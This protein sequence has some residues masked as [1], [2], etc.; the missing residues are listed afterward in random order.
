MK[1]LSM[2][3]VFNKKIYYIILFILLIYLS[4]SL[5]GTKEVRF[6]K[7]NPSEYQFKNPSTAVT[8]FKKI[9]I[10]P[11][12]NFIYINNKTEPLKLTTEDKTLLV[13]FCTSD[14]IIAGKI[15]GYKDNRKS[16]SLDQWS[17]EYLSNKGIDNIEWI[18]K[19]SNSKGYEGFIAK[20][21]YDIRTK[22]ETKSRHIDQEKE[23]ERRIRET[24]KYGRTRQVVQEEEKEIKQF[25][26]FAVIRNDGEVYELTVAVLEDKYDIEKV[27]KQI[28][29]I[30]NSFSNTMRKGNYLTKYGMEIELKSD[31]DYRGSNDYEIATLRY[32]KFNIFV[33]L[34]Y[35]GQELEELR[36]TDIQGYIK[37]KMNLHKSRLKKIIDDYTRDYEALLEEDDEV[38]Y[39]EEGNPIPPDQ[40]MGRDEGFDSYSSIDERRELENKMEENYEEDDINEY[41]ADDYPPGAFME[42]LVAKKSSRKKKKRKDSDVDDDDDDD[43][44]DDDD[45]DDDDKKKG[46]LEIEVEE[47]KVRINEDMEG[48]LAHLRGLEDIDENEIIARFY[49]VYFNRQKLYQISVYYNYQGDEDRQKAIEQKLKELFKGFE[50]VRQ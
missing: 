6:E 17:S 50:V 31:W 28:I 46:E 10:P 25:V 29:S 43:G 19:K 22:I 11:D 18:Y 37:S 14:Y 20:S 21:L 42:L 7:F 27:D 16:L 39:D 38:L 47:E 48:T 3:T 41:K 4:C 2:L 49:F 33:S 30:F 8:N 1:L 23:Q 32:N 24:L 13:E 26:Y 15:V 12:W 9:F 34:S 36:T 35:V 40:R 45:D 5:I 44:D